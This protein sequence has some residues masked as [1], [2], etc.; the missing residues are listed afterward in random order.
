MQETMKPNT[1]NWKT[2][3]IQLLLFNELSNFSDF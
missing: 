3:V 1:K 2:K